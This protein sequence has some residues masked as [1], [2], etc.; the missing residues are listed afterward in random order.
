M[1]NSIAIWLEFK[2]KFL[3]DCEFPKWKGDILR[4]SL[5][6]VLK[7]SFCTTGLNNCFIC[8]MNL[9][10]PYGFIFRNNKT[11]PRGFVRNLK[12]FSKPYVIKPPLETKTKYYKKDSMTFSI[13]LFSEAMK[14]SFDVVN[15]IKILGTKG[16]G[17]KGKQGKFIVEEIL[18]K[19]PFRNNKEVFWEENEFKDVKNFIV[20]DDLKKRITKR[21]FIKFLTPYQLIK[22]KT[23]RVISSFSDIFPFILRKYTNILR[24]YTTYNPRIDIEEVKEFYEYEVSLVNKFNERSVKFVYKNEEQLF[25]LGEYFFKAN[26]KLPKIVNEALNFGVLSNIGKKSVFGFGWYDL[27]RF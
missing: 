19:N 18:S 5:G 24:S 26:K 16:M 11:R 15:A 10:C 2:I 21:F 6:Y 25:F 13:V 7:S 9:A 17:R 20:S 1:K 8:P 27:N 14:F 22:N 23:I 12:Y 4:G 3:N